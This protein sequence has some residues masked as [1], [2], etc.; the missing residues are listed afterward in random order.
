MKS[1]PIAIQNYAN[2]PTAPALDCFAVAPRDLDLLSKIT[3]ARNIGEGS[4]VVLRVA[5]AQADVTFRNLREGD[6]LD[7]R[8]LA[9]RTTRTTAASIV[10]L[11]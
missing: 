11:A 5:N 2:S 8:I 4:V 7:V 6:M 1:I 10:G 3:K 9:G